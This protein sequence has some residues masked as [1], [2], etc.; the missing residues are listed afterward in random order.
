MKVLTA[1]EM[2][3]VDRLTTERYAIPG[4]LLMENAAARAAEAIEQTFGEM[5]SRYVKVVCG[6][7][8]NGGDGAA[9]AR[10]LWMRGALVDVILLGNV[11]NTKGDARTNFDIVRAMAESGCGIGLRE[12]GTRNE[13]WLE[14]EDLEPDLYV[15]AIFG[16]GLTRPAEGVFA[17]AIESLNNRAATRLASLDIDRKSV[18]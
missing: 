10:Q 1:A 16:T 12:V 5:A 6:S 8:N 15:D 14:F 2:R 18:V 3:E 17:D 11:E 9:V 13:V 7:G 4:L